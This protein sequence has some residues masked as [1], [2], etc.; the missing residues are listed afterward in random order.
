MNQELIDDVRSIIVVFIRDELEKDYEE[1][2]QRFPRNAY[3]DD[4]RRP[5][6]LIV[7]AVKNSGP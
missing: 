2:V 4:E 7:K 6:F 3:W 1:L 5:E